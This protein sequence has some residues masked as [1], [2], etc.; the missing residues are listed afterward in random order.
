ML[1]FSKGANKII[2]FFIAFI[3]LLPVTIPK[4]IKENAARIELDKQSQIENVA[5][6]ENLYC[7]EKYAPVKESLF[8][9]FDY[10]K[11]KNTVK[12]NE[13]SFIATHNSYQLECVDSYKNMLDFLNI[14]SFGAINSEVARFE[15]DTLTDQFNLGIRSIELDIETVVSKGEVSFVCVHSP[16]LDSTT[17]CYDL[18][19]ALKEI[20]LWSDANPKH[21][22]ITVIIEP[23]K[24][25]ILHGGM[26]LINVKYLNELDKL[27][28]ETFG[29]KLLTP[30][31]M[32]GEY[33]S[34]KEMREADAWKTLDVCEGKVMFLLHPT[35]TASKR[36]ISQDE[37]LKTQAMFPI[38]RYGDRDKD[39]ASF[40]LMNKPDEAISSKKELLQE[41]KL[42]VRTRVD[43]YGDFSKERT[44]NAF[45]SG[46]QIMSTDYPIK[47]NRAGT[48]HTV[49]FNN[50]KT[51]SL[52]Q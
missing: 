40:I 5:R 31:E 27:L 2:S 50:G 28:R 13:A 26:R 24:A 21:L 45:R 7:D 11:L 34:L 46:S 44:N 41:K 16:V 47:K 35:G 49:A 42:I 23:K 14:A 38:L 8:C 3:S 1:G 25:F 9:D 33:A 37:S 17:S 18:S 6:L 51:V 43:T 29:E 20:K 30:A 19:L 10:D 39:Y 52:N 4:V 15:S 12:L 48:Q 36:Y 32:M 22:P